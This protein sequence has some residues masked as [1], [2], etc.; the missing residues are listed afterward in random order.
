MK[1]STK[2]LSF[3]VWILQQEGVLLQLHESAIKSKCK[4]MCL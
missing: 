4:Y 3:S 1:K 2:Q